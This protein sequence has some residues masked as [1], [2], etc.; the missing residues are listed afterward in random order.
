M[1]RSLAALYS[2][3]HLNGAAEKKKFFR[4]RRFTG[5]RVGNDGE[6]TACFDVAHKR[7]I[8]TRHVKRSNEYGI[9]HLRA[10][11]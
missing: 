5:V 7:R 1:A 2:T 9:R 10:R 6:S 3:R 4:E 8:G 11:L